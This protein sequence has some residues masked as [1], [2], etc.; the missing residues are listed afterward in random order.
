LPKAGLTQAKPTSIK[1]QKLFGM[2][3][4]TRLSKLMHLSWEIQKRKRYSLMQKSRKAKKKRS[5]RSLAVEMAWTIMLTED[6]TVY[7]L[8]RRHSHEHNRNKVVI[9]ELSLFKTT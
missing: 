4:L 8:V 6:I 3:H 7:H 1:S 5:L 9:N 2:Q